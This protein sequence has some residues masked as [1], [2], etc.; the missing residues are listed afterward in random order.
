MNVG[1]LGGGQLGRMLALAAHRLGLRTLV[2][3][4][5]AECP[6]VDVTQVLVGSFEHR[7]D[8]ERLAAASS[9]VTY[10]FENVPVEAARY[11]CERVPVFPPPLALETA[12]DRF[13]EK[14]LFA[15]LEIP[16]PAF[17]TVDTSDDLRFAIE[18]VGLPAVLKTRRMGYDGKGQRVIREATEY[19]AAWMALGGTACILEQFIPFRREL[20]IVAVRDADGGHAFYP[21]VETRHEGGILATARA[22]ADHISPDMQRAAEGCATR[23]LDH[24]DYV[25]VLALEM[26]EHEGRLLGNEFAPRVH[27]SGHWTIDGAE[28]CQFENHLRAVLG[29]PLGSTDTIGCSAMVN[30]IGATPPIANL[31]EIP[32]ARVHLYGKRP[33]PGRKLGHVTVRAEDDDTLQS[34]L[35]A[36]LR[37]VKNVP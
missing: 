13:L 1:I 24:L 23:L 16:T 14:S 9:V 26:F 5:S 28:T 35:D 27:N 37:V 20:S 12:Q 15:K 4:T 22:P 32:H 18:R 33:R 21:L 30:L 6:A 10:E 19:D 29:L 31:L 2:L 3:D 7:G 8:L 36:V 17:V 34:R 25:G 11:L